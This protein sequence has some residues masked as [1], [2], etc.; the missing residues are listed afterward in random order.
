[1]LPKAFCSISVFSSSSLD[2]PQWGLCPH[3][4]DPPTAVDFLRGDKLA[5]TVSSVLL[6]QLL[7]SASSVQLGFFFF[8]LVFYL[9]LPMSTHFCLASVVGLVQESI[10]RPSLV[11][12]DLS[13]VTAWILS[14]VKFPAPQSGTEYFSVY[15][16]PTSNQSL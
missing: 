2:V 10:S 6:V 7:S 9:P 1:M 13:F 8:F 14:S 16:L 5:V 4:L 12:T 11:E 3:I 15:S